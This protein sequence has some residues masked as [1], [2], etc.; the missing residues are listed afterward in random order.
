MALGLAWGLNLVFS[1]FGI[2][3]F[4]PYVFIGLRLT[5]AMTIFA[6]IYLI[7]PQ[8]RW[9][10]NP[11]LWGNAAVAG[12]FGIVVPFSGF[13]VALQFQS[14]GLTSLL[15]TTGPILTVTVAHFLLPDA[16]LKRITLVGVLVA[17][18]GALLIVSR[19]ESGLPDITRANP[20][21][22]L[23]VF[24]ALFS[25]T[26]TIIFIRKRMQSED[27][28]DVTSIR[29]LV[30]ALVILPV[31]LWRNPPDFSAITNMGWGALLFTSVVSTAVAQLLAFYI[32][33]TYGSTSIAMV[34]YVVPLVA[35]IAGVLILGETITLGMVVGMIL[36]VS[37]VLIVNRSK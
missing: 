29:L 13:I 36:I 34:G 15:V 14:A 22:Y 26:F 31:A 35:I 20:I 32:I 16:R 28:F 5:I 4:N 9:P 7:S 3:Q 27:T 2:S 30:A 33:R 12:F 17:L 8:R 1:R 19:G 24:G 21:G 10:R 18:S 25:D 37:G 6:A 23:M 11:R